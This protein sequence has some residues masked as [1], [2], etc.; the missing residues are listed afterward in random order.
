[1]TTGA[2]F[3][4]IREGAGH[5]PDELYRTVLDRTTSPF[6]AIDRD[7]Y[8]TFI[9]G[10]VARISRW[11][12]EDLLGLHMFDL[13]APGQDE[14]ATA[15][16]GELLTEERY[17]LSMPI[18]FALRQP[19]DEPV[20]CEV[21][22]VYLDDVDF[23]GAILRLNPW[24]HL[25]H[26]DHF[27]DSLLGAAPL[28]EVCTHLCL[29][30]SN[31]VNAV[32]AL[33]HHGFDGT[34]FRRTDGG[35]PL[36]HGLPGDEGPWFQAAATQL[37]RSVKVDELP[38]PTRSA[39]VAAGVTRAWCIPVQ[40]VEAV[41]PAVLTVFRA[42][43][44]DPL[45]G[46]RLAIERHCRHV[47][48]ALQRWAEHQRLLYLAGHDSLTGVANRASFRDRLAEAVAI[49][50][51]DLAVAFCDVDD[52]KPF[53]DTY[54]HQTGD[55]VLIQVADRLRQA[56]RSGDE[57]A[58]IGGDEFTIL[59]RNVPDATT[60]QHLIDRLLAAMRKPI[61][62]D[63][64]QLDVAISVGIALICG[65]RSADGLVAR[66]DAALYEAKRNGGNQGRVA[67]E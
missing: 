31:H 65:Q 51:P 63:D 11:R 53:N 37:P 14:K 22:A 52:F 48:L 9:S 27:L 5:L 10:S 40:S 2:N 16:V 36:R 20:W 50:E 29:A 3:L 18:V 49:G 64:A 38:E 17:G 12:A 24:T 44:L 13:L 35:S 19:D 46:H 59:L 28:E 54:G 61:S 55:R 33:I 23:D 34:S 1:M 67:S 4:D 66:A 47:Q 30:I 21:G 62:I 15:A 25:Q 57:L 42:D 60:A 56:L 58:R 32:A 7:G 8:I 39:A 45:M 6:V 26:F 43:D 41:Q